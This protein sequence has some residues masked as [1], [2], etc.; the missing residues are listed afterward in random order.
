M[1]ESDV[2]QSDHLHY[3]FEM[4][5]QFRWEMP[6]VA[7]REAGEGEY[8]GSGEGTVEGPRIKGVARWDLFEKREESR[9]RSNLA[10]VID[11]GE[12][13]PIRFDSRGFFITPDQSNPSQWITTASVHFDT[14]DER[15]AWLNTRL[16]VWV[17]EFDMETFCHHYLVYLPCTE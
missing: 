9:C 13:A 12:A 1:G 14:D 3:L 15:Y 10:G 5:L 17:G 4:N 16:A 11:T 6:P 2:V 8:I 7:S